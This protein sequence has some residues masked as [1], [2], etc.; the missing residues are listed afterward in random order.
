MDL[1]QRNLLL[2]VLESVSAATVLDLISDLMSIPD[3]RLRRGGWR[4]G[5]VPAAGGGAAAANN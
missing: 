3:A 1:G 4:P 2:P 5:L